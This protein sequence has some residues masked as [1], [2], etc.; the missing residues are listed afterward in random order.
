MVNTLENKIY[1]KIYFNSYKYILL[2]V[3]DFLLFWLSEITLWNRY[4]MTKYEINFVYNICLFVKLAFQIFLVNW[5]ISCLIIF[6][7]D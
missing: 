5:I 6:I 1:E 2:Y 4:I 3:D 7:T